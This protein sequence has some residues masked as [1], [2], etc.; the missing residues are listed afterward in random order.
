LTDILASRLSRL[1]GVLSRR[2]KPDEPT[3]V[4]L[5]QQ[6]GEYYTLDEVGSRVWELCDGTRT[7]S[8]IVAAVAAEYDAPVEVIERDVL[9]LLNDLAADQLVIGNP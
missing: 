5:N 9:E 1:P 6:S 8:E 4:L 3:T 7:A 2:V